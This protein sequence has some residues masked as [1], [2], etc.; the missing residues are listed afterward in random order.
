MDIIISHA[1]AMRFWRARRALPADL[2]KAV[3]TQAVIG[4][5]APSRAQLEELRALG[6]A[7]TPNHPID[8]LFGDQASR[9]RTAYVRAH[10]SSV[11]YPAGAFLRVS[12][13]VLIVSPE[14][15]FAQMAE[16][17][18]FEELLLMGCEFCGTFT[19]ATPGGKQAKSVPVMSAASVNAFLD[20]CPKRAVRDSARLSA[21][22]L[23]DNS[24][25]PQ[26]SR[27]ALLLSLPTAYGGYGLPAPV[28]NQEVK[29]QDAAYAI[30]PHTPLRLDLHWPA[31][32]L[33]VEYNGADHDERTADDIARAAALEAQGFDVMMLTH[34]QMYGVDAFDAVARTIAAKL[35]YRLRIRRGDFEERRA[36]LR[37]ALIGS[38]YGNREFAEDR[39]EDSCA[40]LANAAQGGSEPLDA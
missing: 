2:K 22:F 4:G 5:G 21:R 24:A 11:K 27:L 13:H 20:A 14:L 9:S 8:L 31:A 10:T 7:P 40:C 33:D 39:S 15:A 37:K 18:P 25:S 12:P 36:K 3:R 19:L 34:R 6:F 23:L 28:L 26:E 30:Y 1:S 29:M 35:G 16:A 38:V 32:R 17:V